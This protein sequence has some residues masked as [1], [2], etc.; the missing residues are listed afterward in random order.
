MSNG[1]QGPSE[2]ERVEA[3][4]RTLDPLL[5]KFAR[6]RGIVIERNDHDWPAR[7]LDWTSGGLRRT[8]DVSLLDEEGEPEY[9][10]WAAAWTDEEGRRFGRSERLLD[11]ASGE[12]LETALPDLLQA[13][14][15]KAESW[16]R[17]E[18]EPWVE[19]GAEGI[20]WRTVVFVWIPF[21]VLAAAVI[22]AM[23]W[24]L[25]SLLG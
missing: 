4:L 18:L 5:E 17:D 20:S 1:F 8:I 22:F 16:S 25:E 6:N 10:V 13:A 15:R 23:D 24:I 14:R 3:P 11:Q 9:G 21:L 7:R 19:L 12:E 2:W